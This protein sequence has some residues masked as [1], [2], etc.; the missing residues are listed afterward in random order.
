MNLSSLAEEFKCSISKAGDDPLSISGCSN[1]DGHPWEQ[2][3]SRT[4]K[5]AVKQDRS[6]IQHDDNMDQDPYGRR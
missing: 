6:A 5:E 3:G 1:K 4:Q 2:E